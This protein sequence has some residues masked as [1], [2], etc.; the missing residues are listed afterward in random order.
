[1]TLEEIYNKCDLFLFHPEGIEYV[2]NVLENLGYTNKEYSSKEART[3]GLEIINSL[4][5]LNM[6]EIFSWNSTDI[7]TDKNIS[8]REI[9]NRLK[10]VWFVGADFPDFIQMPM[11]KYKHWYLDA[12]EKKGF[13]QH[14]GIWS[15]FV[16]SHIVDL[17]QFIKSN[18]P[19][20]P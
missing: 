12:L 19:K 18:N 10:N 14:K 8:N 17:I 3:E 7:S 9:M 11:F 4:L 16:K 15:G 6:I 2:Y 20:M 5:E 1:M 13:K